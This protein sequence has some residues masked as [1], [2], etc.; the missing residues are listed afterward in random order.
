MRVR[1]KRIMNSVLASVD[2]NPCRANHRSQETVRTARAVPKQ[3]HPPEVVQFE[4]QSRC[5][6]IL[7]W[8]KEIGPDTAADYKMY[9]ND[10]NF[11]ECRGQCEFPEIHPD[12]GSPDESA[13]T[14]MF[15]SPR[16]CAAMEF[17]F[18]RELHVFAISND[19]LLT[20]LCHT[21]SNRL[22]TKINPRHRPIHIP[23]APQPNRKHR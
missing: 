1:R 7:L 16:M 21:N 6:G 22:P 13:A 20:L 11:S 8:Q 9:A 19:N 4:H 2:L 5:P 23:N 17:P 12:A 3:A 10:C 15:S 18:P 14:A